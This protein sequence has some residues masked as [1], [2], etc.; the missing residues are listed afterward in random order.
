MRANR[1]FARRSFMN[2]KFYRDISSPLSLSNPTV[3]QQGF[4]RNR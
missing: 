1:L 4:I 2:R 3:F